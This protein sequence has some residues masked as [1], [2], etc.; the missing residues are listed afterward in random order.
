MN[1]LRFA[2]RLLAKSPGFTAVAVVTLALGIATA[3]TMFTLFDAALLRPLPFF[4]DADRLLVL[5]MVSEKDP[6]PG[7]D[8]EFSMPDLYDVRAR[9]RTLSGILTNDNRTYILQEG[10]RPKRIFGTATTVDGFQLL[11]VQ[12]YR[13]R[14]F[15]PEEA[16]PGAASVVLLGYNL[17]QESFGGRE[18]I[19]GEVV[20]LNEQPVTVIGVMPKNFRFPDNNELWQPFTENTQREEKYRSDHGWQAYARMKPGVTLAQVQAE[21]DTLAAQLAREH[22]ATNT[23]L[24]IRALTARDEATRDTHLALQ[25]MLGAVLAVLL[26]A[27]ANVTNLL[28]ARGATR[29]REIALRLALGAGRGRIVRQVLTE[30]LL[31]G[32]VGGVAGLVL[33]FW[34]LDFVLGFIPEIPYWLRFDLDWRVAAFIATATVGASVLFGTFPALHLSRPDL[35]GELKDGAR[36]TAS[37]QAQRLRSALVVLQLA[38][39]LVLLVLGGLT[40]RSFLRLQRS[41]LG[42]NTE[43]VL[44]FRTGLPPAFVPDEKVALDFFEKVAVQLHRVPGVE[45]AGFINLLPV[46]EAR[47]RHSFLVEGMAEPAFQQDRPLAL[48]R[49]ASPGVFAALQIPLRQGRLFDAHDRAGTPLVA[50]IDQNFADRFF[51]AGDALGRR[52]TFSDPGPKRTWFTIIG[53]VGNISQR[54]ADP[55]QDPAAWLPLA[56]NPDNFASAVVRVKGDPAAYVRAAEDAVLAVRPDIPIYFA[57]PLTRIAHKTLWRQ[58]MFG[59]L[60]ASFAAI[61]LFLAAIGIYGVMSYSVTQRTQEIG[62]RMA[63]GAQAGEVIG[64]MLRQGLRLVVLGLAVGFVGAWF[65]AMTVSGLLHGIAPHDPPTFALVPLLLALVALLACYLPARRATRI[66]PLVALRAE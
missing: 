23:G 4:A 40:M 42:L 15:R 33:S 50:V 62:V 53:V 41:D 14:L 8:F 38:F 19:L 27:C 51:P 5:R 58:R 31:L 10:D 63:L 44:T 21:L 46:S 47:N 55:E 26:I 49:V 16:K 11:G 37:R 60:F 6:A 35:A 22:P 36:G 39:A 30:S 7:H 25:L 57:D 64:M 20:T 34:E 45:S 32:A 61:A 52:I 54:P 66:D 65:A 3:T 17:W 59:G 48:S 56:Q 13:G 2:C 43:H 9:S 24:G 18:D 12:P 28:L 29:S 1:D